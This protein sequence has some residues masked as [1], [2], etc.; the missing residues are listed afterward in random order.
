MFLKGQWQKEVSQWVEVLSCILMVLFALK[1]TLL[2][3]HGPS[4][5][6]LR[7]VTRFGREDIDEPLRAER[8]SGTICVLYEYLPKCPLCKRSSKLWD[9]KTYL[10]DVAQAP[11]LVKPVPVYWDHKLSVGFS[12]ERLTW[13]LL[14]LGDRF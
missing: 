8:E 3:V 13:L 11:S 7:L 10:V 12:K 4:G 14:L 5:Q 6:G 9:K 1:K 2:P